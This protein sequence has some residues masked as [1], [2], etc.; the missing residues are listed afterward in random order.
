MF[1]SKKRRPGRPAKYP[2]EFQC[3]GLGDDA[4]GLLLVSPTASPFDTTNPAVA[5]YQDNMRAIGAEEVDILEGESIS[6]Y[7][8]VL[9]FVEAARRLTT[10]Q[11]RQSST[12]PPTSRSRSRSV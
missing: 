4:E 6:A 3:Q 2:P 5:E 10:S 11:R 9:L 8:S 1:N 7:A 12:R